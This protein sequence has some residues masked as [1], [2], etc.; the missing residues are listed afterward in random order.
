MSERAF[1]GTYSAEGRDAGGSDLGD[2][3]HDVLKVLARIG[4]A[5]R[6]V[7]YLMIGGS[8]V[9]A[10]FGGEQ[11]SGSK[12]ALMKVLSAPGGWLIMLVVAIGLLGYSIWRF[13]QAA[14]DA[15]DHGTD[16]K[17]WVIRGGL[18]VSAISHFLLAI[19]AASAIWQLGGSSGDGGG[20]KTMSAWLMSQPF[21]RWLVGLVGAGII[22]VG[23][24]HAVKGYKE[25]FEKHFTWPPDRR[26]QLGWVC[27]VGLYARS[28]IF[29]IIGCFFLYAA[30]TVNPQ[31]AGGIA[32]AL[33]WL[34][35]QPYGTWLLAAAGAGLLLFAGYSF[36]EAVYRKIRSP[37]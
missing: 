7:V 2:R 19:W 3:A 18:M 15:D 23:I 17:A 36:I 30:W 8:A 5:S 35:E 16:G 34:R 22:G 37:G 28:V 21:G 12:S 27:V 10:A 13:C 14:L 1:S 26:Q 6:G 31:E 9:L 25:K 24:A 33:N 4:Y 20:S 11:V 32:E 29:L